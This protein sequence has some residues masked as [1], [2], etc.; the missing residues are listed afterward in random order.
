MSL[1][2]R[3]AITQGSQ[4]L[5]ITAPARAVVLPDGSNALGP[6]TA[7]PRTVGD[8]VIRAVVETGPE[9]AELEIGGVE[10]PVIDGDQVVIRRT[11]LPLPAELVAERLAQMRAEARRQIDA[12]AEAARG[13]YL[14]PGSGQAI[15]YTRKEE[16]ARRLLAAVAAGQAI[17]PAAY[18]HLAAEV[19]ITAPT[20]EEVANVVVAMADAWSAIS[21]QIEGI[22]LSAKAALAGAATPAE[23]RAVVAGVTWPEPA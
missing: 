19:G 2:D 22:R 20:I 9:A 16:E 10:P 21:A 18:P 5:A 17:D 12:A 8:Y 23:I 4:V 15:V 6:W 7:L 11:V 1:T 13:Q 14:T 3:I